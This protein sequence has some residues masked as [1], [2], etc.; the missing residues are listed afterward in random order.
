VAEVVIETAH[1]TEGGR[2][3]PV[4]SCFQESLLA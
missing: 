4:V 1:S 2:Y 3:S